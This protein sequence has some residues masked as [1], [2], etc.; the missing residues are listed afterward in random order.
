VHFKGNLFEIENDIRR[1]F[2]N[3]FDRRKFVF[4]TFDF[5]SRNRRSFDRGERLMAFPIVVPKPRSNG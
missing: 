3:P 5:Y 4:D 2:G 1:V